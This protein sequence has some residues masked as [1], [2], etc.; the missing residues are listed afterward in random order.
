LGSIRS[1]FPSNVTSLVFPLFIFP[2]NPAKDQFFYWLSYTD[3]MIKPYPISR[4]LQHGLFPFLLASRS[5]QPYPAPSVRESPN[6]APK[7][8]TRCCSE[9]RIAHQPCSPS[10]ALTPPIRNAC[11]H[12]LSAR[13]VP[14]SCVLTSSLS[15]GEEK[16]R[17]GGCSRVTGPWTQERPH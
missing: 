13:H 12:F 2:T 9:E 16:R 4:G 7:T 17:E 3:A 8:R 11:S 15:R 10:A 5:V 14:A 6:A 1:P